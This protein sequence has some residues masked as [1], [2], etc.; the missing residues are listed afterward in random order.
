MI[1]YDKNPVKLRA[2]R[3]PLSEVLWQGRQ[4]AVTT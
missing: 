2:L 1:T 4:W 3:V